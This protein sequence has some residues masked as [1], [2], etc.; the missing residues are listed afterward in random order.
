[1]DSLRCGSIWQALFY[2]L[3]AHGLVFS[4]V[5]PLG[6]E[7]GRGEGSGRLEARLRAPENGEASRTVPE[8]LPSLV[9]E[10]KPLSQENKP[11][12]PAAPSR[13]A[14]TVLPVE[15]PLPEPVP[16]VIASRDS[17]PSQGL[18]H[19]HLE[20]TGAGEESGNRE[21]GA[22]RS[23]IWQETGRSEEDGS[24]FAEY[25]LALKRAMEGARRYPPLARSRG[26][27]G[28][29]VVRLVWTPALAAPRV[30]LAVSSGSS[31]LD[32][33][34]LTLLTRATRITPLPEALRNRSFELSQPMRFSL[35]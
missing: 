18:P 11:I 17:A 27:T 15:T 3:L 28:E 8:V 10:E 22:G 1:M 34:A 26:V 12:S 24:A 7:G 6:L 35:E 9:E 29:V 32:E 33:E 16:E 14:R 25:R 31:L 2:S 30:E 4:A 21:L 13:I 5:I 20:E 23:A 19:R